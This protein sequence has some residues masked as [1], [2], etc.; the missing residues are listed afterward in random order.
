MQIEQ[1]MLAPDF[2]TEDIFGNSI[3]LADY[4]GKKLLIGFFRNAACAICNLR[5]HRM[6][7]RYPEWQA[8]GLEVLAVF[9]AP[10]ANI[11]QYVGKQDAPF[12]I[13]A[14]PQARLYD[15]Y[16][17][18]SSESKVAST[19]QRPEIQ[20]VIGEAAAAGFVLTKEEGSNFYRMP[21]E[22]LIGPDLVV[23]QSHYA[24]YVYDHLPFEV[25]DE[26]IKT[27]ARV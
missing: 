15:L 26:F 11:L 6:I 25:I 5:V 20:S 14:D 1:G 18:E 12:P 24:E 8:Q 21:A 19:M 16:G 3:K 23:S 17:L 13:I 4:R 7:E 9:E 22:F 27:E 10:T 2:Q